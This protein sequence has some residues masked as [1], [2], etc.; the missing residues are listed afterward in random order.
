M[1]Y[2][3]WPLFLP[4]QLLPPSVTSLH[5]SERQV[6]YSATG[7]RV[8]HALCV[9]GLRPAFPHPA[10][11][12][13]HNDQCVCHYTFHQCRHV[14]CC[15]LTR[16]CVKAVRV[17]AETWL[18]YELGEKYHSAIHHH[19][20]KHASVSKPYHSDFSSFAEIFTKSHI[21]RA[22]LHGQWMAA[23]HGLW[24]CLYKKLGWEA[25]NAAVVILTCAPI[26]SFELTCESVCLC[27]CMF[28]LGWSLTQ[29]LVHLQPTR[30]SSESIC[31]RPGSSIPGSPG[32]TIYVSRPRQRPL[33]LPKP[34]TICS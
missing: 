34:I 10:S 22:V 9:S 2:F 21:W 32:H 23:W 4:P 16:I 19:S 20:S 26:L 17:T 29:N 24:M 15:P 31:S 7:S 30:S 27:A 18:R 6:L 3:L 12:W 28:V 14:C 33:S 5:Q 13:P 1:R 8:A 25:A 11:L